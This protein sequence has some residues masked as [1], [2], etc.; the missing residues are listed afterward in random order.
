[1]ASLCPTGSGRLRARARKRRSC[2]EVAMNLPCRLWVG[3]VAVMVGCIVSPGAA[4]ER[5]ERFDKDPGWEGHNNRASTPKPRRVRQD[6]G[7]SRTAHAGG[8]LGE[9]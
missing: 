1:M 8:Q 2:V 9:I 7:Y 4:H 3:P 5:T 6:F